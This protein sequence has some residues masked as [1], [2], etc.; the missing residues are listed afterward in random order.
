M[1]KIQKLPSVLPFYFEA[2]VDSNNGGFPKTFP[3]DLFYDKELSMYRQ[4]NSDALK[5]VGHFLPAM[6]FAWNTNGETVSTDF[7]KLK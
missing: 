2:T 5:E 6:Y 3:F 4:N 1:K 7:S